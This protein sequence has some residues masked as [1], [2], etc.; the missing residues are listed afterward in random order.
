M[1]VYRG[2]QNTQ[3]G[4][5]GGGLS[6]NVIAFN[7]NSGV[8]L[9]EAHSNW[10]ETNMILFNKSDGVNVMD[11]TSN[12]ILFN[13]IAYNVQRGVFVKGTAATGNAILANSIHG[14]GYEGIELFNGGN[15][16]LPAPTITTASASGAAGTGCPGCTIHLFSDSADEGEIYEGF[17]NAGAGG[18]WSYSGPLTGPNVTATNTD[19]GGNTSEFSNPFAMARL[20]LPLVGRNHR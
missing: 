14:N 17:A 1:Y 8:I 10:V 2:P 19:A 11:G 6:G 16:E 3:I 20:L 13:D 15:N 9:W 18:Q 5:S 7:G 4:S 12:A